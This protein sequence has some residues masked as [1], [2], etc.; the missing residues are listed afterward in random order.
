MGATKK[1]NEGRKKG[2]KK[3]NEKKENVTRETLESE[4]EENQTWSAPAERDVER[5]EGRRRRS[6]DENEEKM[7]VAPT[8]Q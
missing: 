7:T 3:I 8:G 2:R 4:G 5:K 6:M 1:E